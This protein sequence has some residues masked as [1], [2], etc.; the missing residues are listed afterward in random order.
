MPS[1]RIVFAGSE[2]DAGG[3]SVWRR[4][5]VECVVNP[6]DVSAFYPRARL[7]VNPLQRGSGVNLK[8]IEAL[9]FSR[10]A[11]TT[12][13]GMRGLPDMVRPYFAVCSSPEAFASAALEILGS[14]E[15]PVDQADRA[16][17]MAEC[18]GPDKLG[19]LLSALHHLRRAGVQQ[20]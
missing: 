5:G 7:V 1:L 18:F 17:L 13:A 12:P 2:P 19:P 10:P 14:E 9:A 3:L 11:V 16:A 15:H 8:M 4:A 6:A 20:F